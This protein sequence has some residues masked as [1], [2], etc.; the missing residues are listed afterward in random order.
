MSN[1]I[2]IT[3]DNF[4]DEVRSSDKPVLLYFWAE[5]CQ[6]CN[7][8]SP[9]VDEIS[10]QYEGKIKVGKINADENHELLKRY[11]VTGFPTILIVDNGGQVVDY[12]VGMDSKKSIEEKIE[13][14]LW[15]Y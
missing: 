13:N 4:Q 3:E 6:P 2:T 11:N 7:I 10:E 14:V 1:V 5:W 8:I 9:I 12:H 15:N